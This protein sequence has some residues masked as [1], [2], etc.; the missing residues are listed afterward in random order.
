MKSEWVSLT[1]AFLSRLTGCVEWEEERTENEKKEDRE[2]VC[3]VPD[4]VHV[5]PQ[6]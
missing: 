6:D 1:N 2:Y 4:S 3:I 5:L